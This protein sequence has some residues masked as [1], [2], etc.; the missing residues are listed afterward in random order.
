MNE[1]KSLLRVAAFVDGFNVYHYL[2]RR[3]YT[4]YKWLN[5]SK[6]AECYLPRNSRLASVHYFTARAT[7]DHDKVLRH[8]IYIRALQ[9]V[10]IKV[11]IGRFKDIKKKIV[12]RNDA[13]NSR[14]STSDGSLY[15]SVF[16]GYTFEEKKTDVNIAC[17][18]VSGAAQDTYDVALLISGDTDFEPAIQT[19]QQIFKKDMIVAVPSKKMS[20]SLKSL[21]PVGH[22]VSIREKDWRF[23][24]SQTR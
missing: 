19:V 1:P 9:H 7:W 22:C 15:G 24:C 6:L 2:L 23:L 17:A 11:T 21:L 13:S 3:G 20:G 18:M 4:K 8:D 16:F 10:G 14:Y 12:I 5:Y